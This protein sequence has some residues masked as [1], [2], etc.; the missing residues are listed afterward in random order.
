MEEEDEGYDYNDMAE[1]EE[2]QDLGPTVEELIERGQQEQQR[3]VEVN[4]M[5]QKRARLA[6]DFRN[7]GRPPVNRD[8]SRLDGVST[9]YR[10]G[11]CASGG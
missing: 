11:V 2:E 3:L 8:L 9:R 10:C 1:D 7:K 5:L 6:L 4:E